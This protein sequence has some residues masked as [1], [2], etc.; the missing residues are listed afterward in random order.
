MNRKRSNR[1]LWRKLLLGLVVAGV[2]LLAVGGGHYSRSVKAQAPDAFLHSLT[3]EE[4]AW[5]RD[6]PVIRVAQDPGWPPIEFTDEHGAPSGMSE[7]YLTLIEQRL[8]VTF[9]RVRTPSWQEAYARLKRWE[10]DMTTSVAVTPERAEFWAFTKPYMEIPI[11]IIAHADVTY[12][13][14]MQELAGEKVAVVDGYAVNDWIPRDFSAIQ[15]VKVD[16]VQDGLQALQRGEVFAYVENMLVVG[17]YLAKL[18]M[19][20]LKIAGDTPYV[21]AQCMAV[22]KDWAPLA[23]ILDKALD[24]IS[25]T[26]RNDIYRKWLPIRYEYG[27]DYTLLWWALTA[28][29]VISLGFILWIRKLTREIEARKNAE[30]SLRESEMRFSTVFHASPAA[31]AITRLNDSKLVDI[32]EAWQMMTG[33]SRTEAIGYTVFELN[34]W[35]DPEQR[36]QLIDTLRAQGAPRA[37]VQIRHKSGEIRDVLMSVEMI[38]VE[39]VQCLLTMAQ[40][41]TERKRAEQKIRESEETYRNL[42][43]NAQVGLFRTRISDGKI[44]E[45]NAQL[46]RMFGYDSREEFIAEYV[47]SQNYVDPGTRERL[48]R[49]LQ[50]NGVVQN[51]QARFYRRDGSIFWVEYS[52]KIYPEKGWIESVVEDITARQEAE[53]ALREALERAEQARR[54]LL[55]VIEDQKQTETALA[56]ERTLLRTLVDNLPDLI[57]VKDLESRFVLVNQASLHTGR[58]NMADI[59]GKTDFEIHPPELAAQYY[60]DDQAVMHSDQPILDREEYNISASQARWF[61]TTKVPLRDGEGQII[62]LVGMSRDITERKQ[63]ETALRESEDRYRRLYENSTIGIYRTTPEGQ[64]LLANPTLVEMLGYTSFD[65][66]AARNLEKKGY[67]SP[68]K[69]AFFLELIEKDGEIKGLESAWTRRDGTAIFVRESARAVRDLQ[70]RTLYYDGVVEDITARKQAENALVTERLLLRTIIDILPALV[71]V[72]DTDCRKILSNRLDMEYM[73]VSTEVEALGKTDFDFYPQDMAARFYA[74]DRAIIQTGQPLLAYEHNL[75][76]ADGQERWLLTFKVPLRDSTGQISG[77]VGVGLDI[78]ERKQ[79]E[80]ALARQAAELQTLYQASQELRRTLDPEQIY[81]AIHHY[82]R[83]SMPCDGLYISAFD[84]ETALIT[85][86]AGW[87][88]DTQLDVSGLPSL[89]LSPDGQGTQSVAIRSG[90][91]LLLNDYE[92][93]RASSQARYY[94]DEQGALHQDIPDDAPRTRSALIVPL[95]VEGKVTGALQVFSDDLNAFSP[96]HLRLLESL[97]AHIA[98]ALQ[99]AALYQVAQREIAERV[100]AEHKLQ[101]YADRLETMVAERTRALEEAQDRLLRQDRLATLG[102]VAGGIAH[103][104]RTPLGVIKNTAYLLNLL[105]EPSDPAIREALD[106]LSQEVSTS[107][108]IITSLLNFARPQRP[109]RQVVDIGK[110]IGH[111][112][113]RV[114][115]PLDVQVTQHIDTDLFLVADAGQIEQVFGNLILNAVQAMPEGGCLTIRTGQHASLPDILPPGF[116]PECSSDAVTGWIVVSIDDT[117]I[118]IAPENLGH[119]FEPLFSTKA[120]G[121]GLGLALVKLLT[122]A[123]GGGVAVTSSPGQ[124]TTFE[125]FWPVIVASGSSVGQDDE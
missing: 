19:T 47:T 7:D 16:T 29:A 49:E 77:L 60:A 107:N 28:F 59:I 37:E 119:I 12:I 24:S 58:Q 22:R 72:K 4:R 94:V 53:A 15:L 31:I 115:I 14:D 20:H 114:E 25:E 95:E 44:L 1:V 40:D 66:L 41:I 26:E 70:G 74:R 103:E 102:Q 120:K 112:L 67:A 125:T 6:H 42:F 118:G 68:Y 9:E 27:F 123:N 80:Q 121:L 85:C 101:D 38:E 65:D 3:E 89:P 32:N 56:A 39:D 2:L 54:V 83:Q 61:S 46:A 71:Y 78:T 43:Q 63:A 90:Q 93:Q 48:L 50:E 100:R 10:I 84:P 11:V 87:N 109:A 23:G 69:R 33:Y 55:S 96:E 30:T 76:K 98:S 51:F 88:G 81:A 108:Q 111:T 91:S 62:G 75:I 35:I 117:G 105:L 79:A 116:M 82:V 124:G 21:N 110:V 36:Q 86:R 106:I 64:I 104:L 8:G 13:A 52:A 122:Q 92:Q 99:N 97:S 5:L 73:G 17:H 34:L 18:K 45:S 113:Q 57:F